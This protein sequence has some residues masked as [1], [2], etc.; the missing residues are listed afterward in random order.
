[1]SGSNEDCWSSVTDD[2]V[3]SPS[4]SASSRSPGVSA[5]NTNRKSESEL[6]A[7]ESRLSVSS[8]SE[9]DSTSLSLQPT[10]NYNSSCS[11]SR[12]PVRKTA[13]NWYSL[14]V[15]QVAV[16]GINCWLLVCTL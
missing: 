3:A 14:P 10:A 9:S 11:Q 13:T 1:M 6:G 2:T 8:T 15:I 16:L 7:T 5:H 4:L 12:K